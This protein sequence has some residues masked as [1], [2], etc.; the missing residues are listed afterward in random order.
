MAEDTGAAV[1]RQVCQA[2]YGKSLRLW[3]LVSR[4]SR[5]QTWEYK[6]SDHGLGSERLTAARRD[7]TRIAPAISTSI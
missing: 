4:P 6:A 5:A 2:S 3:P 7:T 1:R